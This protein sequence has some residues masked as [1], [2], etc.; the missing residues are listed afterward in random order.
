MNPPVRRQHVAGFERVFRIVPRGQKA[1]RFAQ[2]DR[3]RGDIVQVQSQLEEALAAAVGHGFQAEA[4]SRARY[5]LWSDGRTT[6][7]GRRC[8]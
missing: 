7:A 6:C 5:S 1:A 3:A 2:D 4:E 8:A